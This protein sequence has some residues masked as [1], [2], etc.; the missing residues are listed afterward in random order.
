MRRSRATSPPP[1]LG[2]FGRDGPSKPGISPRCGI[3]THMVNRDELNR[4]D[5]ALIPAVDVLN[6]FISRQVTVIGQH[7]FAGEFGNDNVHELGE[8]TVT[9]NGAMLVFEDI[10][11]RKH[12]WKIVEADYALAQIDAASVRFS[13]ARDEYVIFERTAVSTEKRTG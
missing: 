8:C 12:V 1:S 3:F 6:Y 13:N 5:A 9:R 4:T 2:P 11:N 7:L 10:R